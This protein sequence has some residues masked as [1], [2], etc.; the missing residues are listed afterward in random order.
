LRARPALTQAFPDRVLHQHRDELRHPR[1]LVPAGFAAHGID[2]LAGVD[3]V[4][5]L[6]GQLVSHSIEL[7]SE[8]VTAKFLAH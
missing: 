1:A 7:L 5:K 3:A 6:S 4:G 2:D 8:D